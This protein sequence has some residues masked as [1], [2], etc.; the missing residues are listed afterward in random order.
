MEVE[1]AGSS[2]SNPVPGAPSAPGIQLGIQVAGIQVA[3]LKA[4]FKNP[5]WTSRTFLLLCLCIIVDKADQIMLPAVFLQICRVRPPSPP[6][7]PRS[8]S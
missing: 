8:C 1:G 6:A 4:C 2:Y 3:D 7:P 5:A